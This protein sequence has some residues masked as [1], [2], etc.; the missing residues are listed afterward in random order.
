MGYGYNVI[1]SY[2]FL[3][4]GTEMVLRCPRGGLCKA[5]GV[6]PWRFATDLHRMILAFV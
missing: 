6:E 5:C 1:G 4:I 3:E 2:H